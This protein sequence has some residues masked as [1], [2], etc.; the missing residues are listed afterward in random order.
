MGRGKK[1]V[2]EEFREV[3]AV[4]WKEKGW[5]REGEG[6]ES[7][8]KRGGGSS[9]MGRSEKG[10]G[11]KARDAGLPWKGRGR[12]APCGCRGWGRVPC[13]TPGPLREPLGAPVFTAAAPR[14]QREVGHW[15]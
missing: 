13:G 4:G 5:G 2:E 9:A 8:R 11:R 7:I 3:L 15:G 1:V 14:P 12:V 6:K 10:W